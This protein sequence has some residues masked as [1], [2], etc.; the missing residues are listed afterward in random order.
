MLITALA[1]ALAAVADAPKP[2]DFAAVPRSLESEPAYVGAPRY[3]LFLFGE[4]AD[5]R[6]WA[7]LDKSDARRA[8]YDVLYVDLDADGRLGEDGE[9]FPAQS[10]G[11]RE[12]FAIGSFAQPRSDRV[13]EDFELTWTPA[14]VSFKLLWRGEKITMGAYGP[15]RSTYAQFAARLQDAPIFVPGY[16]RPFEFEHWMSGTLTRGKHNEF[17]VF[18]GNR[19]SVRGA[20]CT[21]NDKFLPA[22]EFVLATLVYTGSD[23]KRKEVQAKLERRC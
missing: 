20:F 3:G 21:V 13:H 9:R 23:G 2:I 6:V 4:H 14:C 18:V 10:A 5:V 12:V 7:A 16:D 22:D 19:G 8:G 17:K 1:C 11:A 15:E